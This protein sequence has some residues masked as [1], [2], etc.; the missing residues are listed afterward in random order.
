MCIRDRAKVDLLVIFIFF[1]RIITLP[2]SL[3]LAYW[4]LI[5]IVAG[6]FTPEADGGVAHWAHVGGFVVGGLLAVPLWLR[7]GGPAFWQATEGIPPH[8]PAATRLRRTQVP[9]IRRRR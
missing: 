1:I 8:P 3:V 4:F 5:Q 6:A 7:L 9:V 2:A